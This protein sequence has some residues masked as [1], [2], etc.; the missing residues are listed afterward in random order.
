MKF[1]MANAA[2]MPM[3]ATTITSSTNVKPAFVLRRRFSMTRPP[4]HDHSHLR[5][6][7]FTCAMKVPYQADKISTR[8]GS[9]EPAI[10]CEGEGELNECV[11]TLKYEKGLD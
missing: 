1:G 3:I 7:P 4:Y 8:K 11:Q 9:P 6:V 10:R 2:R 5:S